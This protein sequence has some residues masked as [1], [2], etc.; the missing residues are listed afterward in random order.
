VT[1]DVYDIAGRLVV[2]LV[3][4]VQGAGAHIEKWNGQ[5][6]A[7]C[8]VASGTYFYRMT[9]EGRSLVRKMLLVR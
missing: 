6:R 2:R 4:G 3:D 7:G 5:D 9:T 8:P 1:L